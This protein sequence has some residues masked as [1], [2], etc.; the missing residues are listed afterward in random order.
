MLA[1]MRKQRA[2]ILCELAIDFISLDQDFGD[3]QSNQYEV[4]G[5]FVEVRFIVCEG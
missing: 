2:T 1:M 3:G 4:F 5:I